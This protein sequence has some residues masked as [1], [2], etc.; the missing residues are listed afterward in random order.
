VSSPGW[1]L[2]RQAISWK[3][4]VSIAQQLKP[5]HDWVWAPAFSSMFLQ[6][7]CFRVRET[8]IFTG[9]I[10]DTT[11]H[12]KLHS[13]SKLQTYNLILDK[14]TWKDSYY[15]RCLY[16]KCSG[17]PTTSKRGTRNLKT[18]SNLELSE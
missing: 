8:L 15:Q 3:K 12:D 9:H 10:H 11:L 4:D 2:Y 18:P 16:S 6:K 17:K 7:Y 5:F 1:C 13:K 14:F